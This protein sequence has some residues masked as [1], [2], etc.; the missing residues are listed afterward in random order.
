MASKIIEPEIVSTLKGPAALKRNYKTLYEAR[1]TA[2]DIVER[3]QNK[4]EKSQDEVAILQKSKALAKDVEVDMIVILERLKPE[5]NKESPPKED[6]EERLNNLECVTQV[7]TKCLNLD[8]EKEPPIQKINVIDGYESS[9]EED[10]HSNQDP[11]EAPASSDDDSENSHAPTQKAY[12]MYG[13]E[14]SDEEEVYPNEA[15][16]SGD[17]DPET[18]HVP[19]EE[20]EDEYE[21][22]TIHQA[23]YHCP[24]E[25]IDFNDDEDDYHGDYDSGD[26]E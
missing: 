1:E 24:I 22:E 13:Y 18:L 16:A 26:S 15:S 11:T 20:Q 12:I 9:D 8:K 2:K 7:L 5:N 25:D 17:D 10:I 23:G 3:I 4:I 14:S 21:G 6:I 19:N